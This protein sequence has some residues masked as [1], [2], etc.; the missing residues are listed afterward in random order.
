MR[1][2]SGSCA[3][4]RP[5]RKNLFRIFGLCQLMPLLRGAH[6]PK[7]RFGDPYTLLQPVRE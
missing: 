5:I 6:N 7:P 2:C 4:I 1:V 3:G